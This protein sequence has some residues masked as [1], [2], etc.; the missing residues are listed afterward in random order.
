MRSR[1]FIWAALTPFIVGCDRPQGTN[2]PEMSAYQEP[3]IVSIADTLFVVDDRNTQQHPLHNVRAAAF[4]TDGIAIANAGA[5]EILRLDSTGALTAVYGKVGSGPGEFQALHSLW[6]RGDTMVAFDLALSRLQYFVAPK[7][8]VRSQVLSRE[9]HVL[10]GW[11]SDDLALDVDLGGAGPPPEGKSVTDTA[12]FRVYAPLT[13]VMD[14]VLRLPWQERYGATLP[15][16]GVLVLV[17]PL[18]PKGV[19]AARAG[20]IYAGTARSWQIVR[21]ADGASDTLTFSIPRRALSQAILSTWQ[22]QQ[23]KYSTVP[24]PVFRRY[25]ESL[26]Y[27]DTLPA[28]DKMVADESGR[29]WIREFAVPGA[30][31]ARWIV[32][33]RN[34]ELIGA[35][36]LSAEE[37]IMDVRGDSIVVLSTPVEAPQTIRMYRVA[38]PERR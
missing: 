9:E 30:A 8:Y 28:Y 38:I 12:V 27:P 13:G 7:G 4:T 32:S 34:G 29:I 1:D 10:A 19:V 3:A 25:L 23:L 26:P 22:L 21:Y 16:G 14:T 37:A 35:L 20:S 24:R 11:L 33:T 5:A 17:L 31:S 18:H 36:S 15:D 6:A 2:G